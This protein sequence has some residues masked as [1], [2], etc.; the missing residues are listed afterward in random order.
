VIVLKT[1]SI[2]IGPWNHVAMAGIGAY[3]GYH[4]Q[5]WENQLLVDVNEKRVQ[6]GLIP[7]SRESLEITSILGSSSE[8]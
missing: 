5:S 7:I 6:R 4:F 2:N 8:N 1:N 3:I